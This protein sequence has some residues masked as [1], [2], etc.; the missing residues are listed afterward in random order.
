MVHF[1]CGHKTLLYCDLLKLNL[2]T[3]GLDFGQKVQRN[4]LFYKS[5]FKDVPWLRLVQPELCM[6]V[7]TFGGRAFPGLL[8]DKFLR[9]V[10]LATQ[11]S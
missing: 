8:F 11:C 9:K 3:L 10:Y 7:H 5:L 4:N 1:Q 2:A 6:H